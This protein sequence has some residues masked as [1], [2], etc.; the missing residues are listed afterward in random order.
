MK[1]VFCILNG[2]GEVVEEHGSEITVKFSNKSELVKYT[3]DG[4]LKFPDGSL[5][6]KRVLFEIEPKIVVDNIIIDDAGKTIEDKDLI[7]FGKKGSFVFQAGFFDAKNNSL[8]TKDGFRDAN[9]LFKTINPDVFIYKVECVSLESLKEKLQDKE[10][11]KANKE[12]TITPLEKFDEITKI[13]QTDEN[14]ISKVQ[15]NIKE[16]TE[17]KEMKTEDNYI[18][19]KVE[20]GKVLKYKGEGVQIKEGFALISEKIEKKATI[21]IEKKIEIGTNG[22]AVLSFIPSQIYK[23]VKNNSVNDVKNYVNVFDAFLTIK[24]GAKETQKNLTSSN[25]S[26][27]I[28]N[29]T[30]IIDFI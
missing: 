28:Q 3:K 15:E 12:H 11:P 19:L 8:F 4:Y 13:A 30:L 21:E 18:T 26:F 10:S 5:S 16:T 7:I 2:N 22:F 27:D 20:G 1:Q 17:K 9:A 14:N 23:I 24:K 29:N 6:A 25:I